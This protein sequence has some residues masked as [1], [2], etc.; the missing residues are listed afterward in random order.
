MNIAVKEKEQVFNFV[1]TTFAEA[2]KYAQI[3][4][5][6]TFCPKDFKGKP[7]DVLIAMQLGNEIGLK[8]LQALQN[9]AVINGR[10]SMWGD[11]VWAIVQ[12]QPDLED[13]KE[14]IEG[15]GVN[16]VAYCI[17]KKKG[18]EPVIGKFS[19]EDAKRAGL[20]GKAGPWTHYENRMFQMRARGFASRDAYAHALKGINIAEEMEDMPQEKDITNAASSNLNNY[21]EGKSA[22]YEKPADAAATDKPEQISAQ[23]NQFIEKDIIIRVINSAKTVDDL[24]DI[25]RKNI[26]PGD[27]EDV[28]NAYNKKKKELS[29]PAPQQSNAEAGQQSNA[30][31]VADMDEK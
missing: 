11:A 3:I 2:S 28:K 5:E 20:I 14:Y 24:S 17:I 22:T 26:A 1:A 19:Y 6:S 16:K 25:N 4:S 12:S 31:W 15:Q 23:E 21:L 30:E 8:P 29:A 10:P 9:I 27:Y 13:T 18:K 7:G